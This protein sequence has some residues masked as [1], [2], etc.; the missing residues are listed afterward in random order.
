[1]RFGVTQ[2]ALRPRLIELAD[3][4]RVA[5]TQRG[6]PADLRTL[7]GPYRVALLSR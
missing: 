1:M 5:I 7:R 6:L 2:V 3:A 4:G